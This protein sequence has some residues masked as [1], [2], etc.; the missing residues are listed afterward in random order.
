MGLAF[1]QAK[2]E[3]KRRT[4]LVQLLGEYVTLKKKGR[5]HVGLCPFHGERSPSLHVHDAEG[6]YY[7]F[8]CQARGDHYTFLM[9]H[10]GYSFIEAV[11]LLS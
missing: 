7:C 1:E 5:D 10:V 6:Y 8:G 3:I 4:S 11:K 2:D 9:E